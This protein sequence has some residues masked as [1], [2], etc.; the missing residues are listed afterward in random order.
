M[1]LKYIYFV[2]WNNNVFKMFFFDERKK[3][4]K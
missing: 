1:I 4:T 2:L 3:K